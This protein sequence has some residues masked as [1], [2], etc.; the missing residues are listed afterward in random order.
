MMI[1][2]FSMH[3]NPKIVNPSTPR[4]GGW[5]RG[6]SLPAGRQGLTL[7]FDRLSIPSLQKEAA[8]SFLSAVERVN[9]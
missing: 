6:L 5:G 3:S 8:P 2:G 4:P 1:T 9:I 7:S